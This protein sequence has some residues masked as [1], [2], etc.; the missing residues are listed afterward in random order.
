[1]QYYRL[2]Q[3]FASL[4]AFSFVRECIV[5]THLAFV[6]KPSEGGRPLS[7][8]AI[9]G[10]AVAGCVAL[11]ATCAICAVVLL[12]RK[13]KAEARKHRDLRSVASSELSK[14][15]ICMCMHSCY[16]CGQF[17]RIRGYLKSSDG[18]F[19]ATKSM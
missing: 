3:A 10:I 5:Q 7:T 6:E 12:L 4:S 19:H 13:R 9:I 2:S 16:C 11:L 15:G 17:A 8:A 18:F 1:M 14:V